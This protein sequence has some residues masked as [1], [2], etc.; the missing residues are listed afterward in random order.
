MERG[1]IDRWRTRDVFARSLTKD[2]PRGSWVFYEGPPTANGKPGVHHVSARAFKDLFPRF[3]TMQG[4]HVDRKAGWDTHGL[5]V[6]IAIERR[7]GFSSKQQ[8]EEYGIEAFNRLCREYV[9]ENIQE[10]NDMTERI[11]YWLDLEHAY[12]TYHGS[13]IESCWWVFKE[14]W[15]RGWLTEDFKT[16][17]HSPSSNTTLASHE[18][19]LGYAEDV[20]DPSVYPAF[21]ADVG[22]MRDRGLLSGDVDLPVRFLAWTTTPWTLA[23][24][25]ALAVSHDAR[26]ALV[27]APT[28]R[29]DAGERTAF[30]LASDRIEATFGNDPYEVLASFPGRALEGVRYQPI[31]RGKVDGTEEDRVERRVVLDDM[32]SLDDGTGVVHLAP[33]YGDLDLGR[34]HGLATAFSVSLTGEV[35]PEVAPLDHPIGVDGPYTGMWF[36]DADAAIARDLVACGAMYHVTTI[37][38]AYP[39]NWRD[40]KPL[41]NVAKKSWY[42]RTTAVKDVLLSNND[43]V[44]WVPD[45]VRTGRFGKWLENNVDWAISRERY[46]GC[47]LP[48]WEAEDG[49]DHL[50]IGSVAELSTLAGRDLTGMDLHRPFVDEVTFVKEGKTYRRVPYTVDVWFESGAMPYAQHHYMGDDSTEAERLAFESAFP[51]DYICEAI[52]QTRGWFYSLHALGT[53]LTF[54]GD[55]ERPAGPLARLAPNASAFA[56]VIVLG[57]IVDENGEKMSKSKGNV[58]DPWSVLDV[59]GADALRWYLYASSPPESTKR[60]SSALVEEARRDFLMTLWNVYGFFVMYANLDRPDLTRLDVPFDERPAIDRWLSS[61]LHRT[62]RTVT[63]RL[64]AFDATG[65]ARAIRDYVVDDLSN[66]Y[67]R[68]NRKRFWKSSD[69]RDQASA[70]HALYEALVTVSKWIA[71]MTPFVADEIY[72]NL[73]TRVDR[74]APDSV[75]LASWPAAASDVIDDDLE[76]SMGVVTRLVELGRAARAKSG[77]KIRQPLRSVRVRL[78]SDV[79]RASVEAL[80]TQLLEE[81]NVHSVSYLDPADAFVA[82][83]VKPNLPL[84]GRRMGPKIPALRTALAAADGRAIAAAVAAGVS[85]AVELD[86]ERLDLEPEAFLLDARSPEG[87]VAVEDRGF[88]VALDVELDDE[89][90]LEGVARDIVR[91]VQNARKSAGFDV[92][93]RIDVLWSSDDDEVRRAVEVHGSEIAEETLA[94]TFVGTDDAREA[95]AVRDATEFTVSSGPLDSESSAE[96]IVAVRIHAG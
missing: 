95:A 57:H 12:V 23:A 89:L 42:I 93:D 9:F 2:A 52:D 7:L 44:R 69:A 55:D 91:W 41:M 13:Y 48:I 21:L 54:A 58:V 75:H 1:V 94:I 70:Y 45:H 66:W 37:R 64:E 90:R 80:E 86:G 51:A 31:L 56:N 67:V 79:D 76:R 50:C 39:F 26:Y 46:W 25:T 29:G 63:E 96:L 22:D 62:T 43:A 81:L 53:L 14:L 74:D 35:L 34:K 19:S 20:E 3:K 60:F 82:Y 88:L 36:K 4:F 40:G 65:A 30:V 8:I 18:V 11:G 77:I 85:Y 16:T 27:A 83:D 17:W 71:P 84:L 68:R 72:V 59:Q 61:R 33:A 28:R 5:P 24:N 10:W 87:T 73:A 92:S 6:E 47:P 15:K 78:P 49:S 32:V 38:H